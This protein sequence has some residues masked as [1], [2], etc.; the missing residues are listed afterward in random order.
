MNSFNELRLT[1]EQSSVLP[2]SII[3]MLLNAKVYALIESGI[4]TVDQ[5]CDIWTYYRKISDEQY[6]DEILSQLLKVISD[7][8]KVFK[9]N[10]TLKQLFDA[11]TKV[12][13]RCKISIAKDEFQ[14]LFSKKGIRSFKS[15][16][17]SLV[18]LVSYE[19]YDVQPYMTD[20]AYEFHIDESLPSIS[21][22]EA[23]RFKEKMLALIFSSAG[24]TALSKRIVTLGLIT[25]INEPRLLSLLGSK[26]AIDFYSNSSTATLLPVK[27]IIA[28]QQNL[29]L[30]ILKQIFGNGKV[31][32]LFHQQEFAAMIDLL[33]GENFPPREIMKFVSFCFSVFPSHP[34]MK[35]IGLRFLTNHRYTQLIRDG[36]V[37]T[38]LEFGE[39]GN[40][41]DD[42]SEFTQNLLPYLASNTI[43]TDDQ[44][45]TELD[46]AYRQ[47][48]AQGPKRMYRSD[49]LNKDWVLYKRLNRTL[50]FKEK[51]SE[52]YLAFKIQT[53]EV[54]SHYSLYRQCAAEQFLRKH[55]QINSRSLMPI[56]HG[57]Y[58][59]LDLEELTSALDTDE[60]L[61]LE[62]TIGS[63]YFYKKLVYI[64]ETNDPGMFEY[65]HQ[66]YDKLFAGLYAA[67]SDLF[68]YLN[69]GVAYDSIARFLHSNDGSLGL[70]GDRGRYLTLTKLMRKLRDFRV[71]I[72]GAGRIHAWERAV[73]DHD[74]RLPGLVDR[75]DYVILKTL[76]D[77]MA[78][79]VYPH[80]RLAYEKY[81]YDKSRTNAAIKMNFMAEYLLV[82]ELI[83]GRAIRE[84]PPEDSKQWQRGVDMLVLLYSCGFS[85]MTG[86]PEDVCY[87]FWMMTMN[88]TRYS[89]QMQFW[90][91]DEYL[92]F[93]PQEKLP[94]DVYGEQTKLRFV[95]M[96]KG[97]YS[98]VLGHSFD[99][100]NRDLGAT[101]G[102]YPIKAGDGSRYKFATF[103]MLFTHNLH[104]MLNSIGIFERVVER[105]KRLIG[106]LERIIYRDKSDNKQHNIHKILALRFLI[107]DLEIRTRYLRKNYFLTA[108]QLV[109]RYH[110]YF[111]APEISEINRIFAFFNI[112]VDVAKV[113]TTQALLPF[114][115]AI[116]H[117]ILELNDN[118]Q[119]YV[120]QESAARC[121]QRAWRERQH[122]KHVDKFIELEGRPDFKW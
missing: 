54:G 77:K 65:C 84:H 26:R 10:F 106:L 51:A 91:S 76:P 66:H 71:R 79:G 8:P 1:E 122:K 96:R 23:K 63:D 99:G 12:V 64:Y 116:T 4:L 109:S 112:K 82:L 121:I 38:E 31:G 74:L 111:S 36:L 97:T 2:E 80:L 119:A 39:G 85:Q 110:Q 88:T 102:Q 70:R 22:V 103:A 55:R 95:P 120:V 41:A 105:N 75:G 32:R 46:R 108:Q 113:M 13:D 83:I 17:L 72:T 86:I 107:N 115:P 21:H 15:G 33:I 49:M 45:S 7:N 90:M 57:I 18:K 47:L 35:I 44:F 24:R 43:P 94:D 25:K 34:D 40:A 9:N 68:T 27:T 81:K 67:T 100:K 48:M 60:K 98:E 92:K 16:I 14:L 56:A 89:R 30:S 52:R 73:D 78:N 53:K 3:Q 50:V 37:L 87:Q 5:I 11:R 28:H 93:Y 118:L 59:I 58:H 19:K 61:A 69:H 6:I 101:N 20:D 114:I 117:M 62:K 29:P 42:W 104:M